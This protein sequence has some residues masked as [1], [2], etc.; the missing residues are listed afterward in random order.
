MHL[1]VNRGNVTKDAASRVR[2]AAL[3]NL[4][5]N[6]QTLNLRDRGFHGK[7]SFLFDFI[8]KFIAEMEGFENPCG[9][10]DVA[11]GMVTVNGFGRILMSLGGGSVAMILGGR[12]GLTASAAA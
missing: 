3:N 7:S 8:E 6:R 2:L 10:N 9:V 12:Q 11:Y 5:V 1:H 4:D